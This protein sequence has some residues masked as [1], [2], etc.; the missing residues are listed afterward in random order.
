MTAEEGELARNLGF[1]EAMTL[2]GG[3][4]IG[5]GIFILP[6]IAAEGAGPASS[7]SFAIAGV[8]ALL[9]ALSIS[10]L[11]TGMPVA[12][13]SYVYVNRAL[14]DLFG[15]IVGWGMWT[16]LMFASAFYM[17]GFGQYIVEPL[18]FLSGRVL[19]VGLG[20]VGLL[21]LVGVNYKGTEESGAFQ[22]WMIGIETVIILIYLAFG[23]F[24]INPSNLEPF[25]PTGPSG[26]IA[27]TGIVF[28]TFLG[29]E[30]IATVAEEI[31]DPG[32][33]IPL[34]MVLSV[35]SV[36]ILYV[37]VMIVS[38]GV[39]NWQELGGS[40]VP[41]SDVA[42]ISMGPIGVI[43]IVSAAAIAAISSSNSSILSAAR[44]VF[45]M[46]RDGVMSNKLNVTHRKFRT[47]HRAV[48]VTGAITAALIS[49]GLRIEEIVA[50]LA[51][52]ASFSFL[53]SYTL[54]HVAVVVVRRA[55][56]ENYDPEFEMP[57]LLYPAV[58]ILGVILSFVVISQMAPIVQ[59]I[60]IGII[61]LSVLWYFGYVRGRVDDDTL[62]GDAIVGNGDE[63]EG[64]EE[65]Y[66]VVVPIAN[67]ETQGTLLRLAA[68][69]A[70]SHS[71]V[72]QP[73]I[74]ALNVIKVPSQT[75][76]EQN[77]Q[78]EEERVERQRELF[79]SA[80]EAAGEL[81]V[82]LRTRAIV[83]RS[84]GQ[85]VLGVLEEEDANQVLLGWH[86]TKRKRD[87]VFGSTVDPIIR[88]APCEVTVVNLKR[89]R[90]GHPVAL[91]GPGPHAPV[92]ARRAFEFAQIQGQIPTLVNFQPSVDDRETDEETP[93]PYEEG[94]IAIDA[95]AEQAGLA[96]DDYD[97]RVLVGGDLESTIISNIGSDEFVCVGVSEQQAIS[98]ILR[99][100]L[101]DR[102]VQDA[103]GNV[104]LIRSGIKTH[105]T[106]REG[107]VERLSQG[108]EEE[109][110]SDDDASI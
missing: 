75:A 48:M 12:G 28:V 63:R 68:A 15:S 95:V 32:R 79:E 58:P 36:S 80:R 43:A 105:R 88:D 71:E 108:P 81:G 35:V 44:V 69:S 1:L 10:E 50:L 74:I 94:Q 106:V 16:G 26:I 78:F 86:G 29:F 6:G 109:S 100:S 40:L 13:G 5:A 19:I 56:P 11:A 87:Y 14:G 70:R 37:I 4:M 21:F 3:T 103:T 34:T 92:A 18:P 20:L 23:I 66:R 39:I 49:L 54:V 17:I 9:A 61:A 65:T 84:I 55:E 89:E 2:G 64:T 62:V 57:S 82:N 24:F 30:I 97:S 76:L 46:G 7:L 41:V 99:G 60:G 51:E 72:E 102:I 98:K 90:I 73:E 91:A 107:I 27:T 53:V 42:A 96:P 47:P 77:L 101:A 31:K 25:A 8:V 22:N 104:A 85:I 52:V 93:D 59:Y 38:T 45:A 33:L 83:G 67:P 110:Q